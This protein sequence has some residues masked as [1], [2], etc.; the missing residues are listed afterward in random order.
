MLITDTRCSY[1]RTGDDTGV[2]G[3]AIATHENNM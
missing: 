2:D 1:V 3:V